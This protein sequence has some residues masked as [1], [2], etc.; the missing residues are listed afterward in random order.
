MI[1]W[2]QL[3]NGNTENWILGLLFARSKMLRKS[4]NLS[5]IDFYLQNQRVRVNNTFSYI[6]GSMILGILYKLF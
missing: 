5:G 6:L 3:G 2:K 1:Q 4:F